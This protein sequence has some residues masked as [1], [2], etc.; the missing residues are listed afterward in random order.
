MIICVNIFARMDTGRS[1]RKTGFKIAIFLIFIVWMISV[2]QFHLSPSFEEKVKGEQ[3]VLENRDKVLGLEKTVVQALSGANST[4][5]IVI[6]NLVTGESFFQ[7]ENRSFASASLYKLWLAKIVYQHIKEGRMAFTDEITEDIAALNSYYGISD[8][9]AEFTSGVYSL[10]VGEAIHQMITISHNNSALALAKKVKARNIMPQ[11]TP[12]QVAE[13]F[14]DLYFGKMIDAT[15]SSQLLAVLKKQENKEM[16]P[17]LLPKETVVA[18]KTGNLGKFTHDAGIVFSPK[19]DYVIVLMSE[20]DYP[21]GA[22]ERMAQVS[23]AVWDYFT[24]Q[25]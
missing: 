17:N 23:K 1:S 6:K 22:K 3:V 25:D 13:F 5:G 11:V 12:L 16:I 10:T 18:H 14:E 4:Y 24:S 19:G 20:S 8:E 15:A 7:N 21:P 9:D 2:W